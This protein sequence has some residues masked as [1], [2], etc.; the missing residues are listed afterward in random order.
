[1]LKISNPA[2]DQ[3][4][5]AM[6][7]VAGARVGDEV[8]AIGTPLAYLVT[9]AIIW[10]GYAVLRRLGWLTGGTVLLG[11][12]ITGTVAVPLGWHGVIGRPHTEWLLYLSGATAGGVAAAIFWVLHPPQPER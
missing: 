2:P 8:I 9:A 11:G 5:I 3:A 4:V 6:G 10:P 7:S 12:T 1:M